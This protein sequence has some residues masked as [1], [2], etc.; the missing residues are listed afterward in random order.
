LSIKIST[1]FSPIFSNNKHGETKTMNTTRQ[2]VCTL[3]ILLWLLGLSSVA[4][5]DTVGPILSMPPHP[6]GH[7]DRVRSVAISPDGRYALSGSEDNTLKLWDIETGAEIRTL[8]GSNFRNR[9]SNF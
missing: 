4:K 7:N 6:V 1:V 8:S 5:A 3:I 2:T 9:Y